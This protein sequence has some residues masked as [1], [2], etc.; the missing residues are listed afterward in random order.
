MVV[1]KF[2]AVNVVVVFAML[3]TDEANVLDGE[4]SQRV[5][6][7]VCPLKVNTVELVPVQTVALPAIVPPT[8]AGLTVTVAVALFAAAQD[9]LVTTAL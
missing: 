1:V 5:T 4:D 6:F 3:V 8:D 2:V 7:P 9:P